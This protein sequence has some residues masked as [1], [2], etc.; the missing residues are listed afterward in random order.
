M[1]LLLLILSCSVAVASAAIPAGYAEKL[2]DAI[3]LAEGGNRTSKP[4]GIMAGRPLQPNEAR[5]WC[6]NTIRNNWRHWEAGGRKGEFLNFLAGIYCPV[7]AKND[8]KG[9]NK[10][11]LRNVK[12]VLKN[13]GH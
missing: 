8:P 7:G 1:K 5:K 13:Q 9:L 10:N 4:Y 12:A 11:W 3:Y 2:A 6:L